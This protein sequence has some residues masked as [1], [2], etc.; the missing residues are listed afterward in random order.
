MKE[1]ESV[2][3][4]VV[5]N[6]IEFPDIDWREEKDRPSLNENAQQAFEIISNHKEEIMGELI[7][8]ENAEM[9]KEDYPF[10]ENMTRGLGYTIESPNVFV[11]QFSPGLWYGQCVRVELTEKDET[12]R[13]RA[14]LDLVISEQRSAGSLLGVIEQV[15]AQ[16]GYEVSTNR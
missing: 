5:T 15:L 3:R 1:G 12:G 8:L 11:V 13:Q 9:N 2:E 4:G 16:Q 6:G 7:R 14:E 10:P